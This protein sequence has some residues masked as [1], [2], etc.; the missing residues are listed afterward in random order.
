[1]EIGYGLSLC[2]KIVIFYRD[3][4]PYILEE[5]GETISHIKTYK[6][7][8]FNEIQKIVTM[9]GMDIFDGGNDE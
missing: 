5:A 6:Y 4:L 1:V 2:K 9:N 3:K 7:D 8:N